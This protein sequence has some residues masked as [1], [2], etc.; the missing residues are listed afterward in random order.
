MWA[1]GGNPYMNAENAEAHCSTLAAS[2][3]AA[4]QIET[5]DPHYSVTFVMLSTSGASM[6]EGMFDE[7]TGPET[8]QPVPPNSRN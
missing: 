6:I 7:A 3:Q 4:F 5:S 8:K 2:S 1:N